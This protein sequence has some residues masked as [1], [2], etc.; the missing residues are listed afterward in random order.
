MS[1]GFGSQGSQMVSMLDS[2]SGD[3]GLSPDQVHAVVY[4]GKTLYSLSAS[5]T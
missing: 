3:F 1:N 2:G 5:L 4:L